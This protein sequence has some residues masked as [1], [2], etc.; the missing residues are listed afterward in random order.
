MFKFNVS[1]RNYQLYSSC[2]KAHKRYIQN[3]LPTT[4]I[5]AKVLRH[6]SLKQLLKKH[7]STYPSKKAKFIKKRKNFRK[8]KFFFLPRRVKLRNVN[9]IEALSKAMSV[10]TNSLYFGAIARNISI[11]R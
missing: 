9:I 5:Y 8:Y 11:N 6:Q 7:Y 10:A 4:L 2:L 3:W 1:V